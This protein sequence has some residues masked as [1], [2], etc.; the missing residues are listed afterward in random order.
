MESLNADCLQF[1]A[2]II[3]SFVLSRQLG[4]RL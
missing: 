4:V 2:K 1:S 3:E